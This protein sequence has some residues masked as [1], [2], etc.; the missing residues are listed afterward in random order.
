MK[1]IDKPVFMIANLKPGARVELAT[2]QG[3]THGQMLRFIDGTI[4]ADLRCVVLLPVGGGVWAE[5][6]FDHWGRELTP[7]GAV[8]TGVRITDWD[9]GDNWHAVFTGGKYRLGD[10]VRKASGSQWHGT[11]VGY[12]ATDLTER[13]YAIESAYEKGSVQIYPEAA[14]APWKPEKEHA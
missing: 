13:G 9:G 7:P 5:R 2:A 3:T 6:E 11:V 4:A 1:P 10:T 8:P 12:Y 14:L